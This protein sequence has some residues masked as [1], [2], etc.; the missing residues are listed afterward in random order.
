MEVDATSAVEPLRLRYC[1]DSLGDSHRPAPYLDCNRRGHRLVA[2]A[3]RSADGSLETED[4]HQ[5]DHHHPAPEVPGEVNRAAAELAKTSRWWWRR[6][7][8]AT[9]CCW[10]LVA[11]REQA[12]DQKES[13]RAEPQTIELSGCRESASNY[14]TATPCLQSRPSWRR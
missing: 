14:R 4:R 6:E 11:S 12:G 7:N 13:A 5:L 8:G 1:V 2:A 3:A 10:T 9:E